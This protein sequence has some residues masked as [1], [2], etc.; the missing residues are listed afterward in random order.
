MLRLARLWQLPLQ[1]YTHLLIA[2]AYKLQHNHGIPPVYPSVS[3]MHG[4][5]AGRR[6][7]TTHLRTQILTRMRNVEVVKLEAPRDKQ[8]MMKVGALCSLH[9]YNQVHMQEHEA[10]MYM[11]MHGWRGH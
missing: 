10:H 6:G 8:H 2:H 4:S 11:A 5:M 9:R 7:V 3:M 1:F